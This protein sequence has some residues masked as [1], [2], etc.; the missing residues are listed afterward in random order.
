[1][2]CQHCDSNKNLLKNSTRPDGKIQ[3][4]CR[5]CNTERAKK[6]RKTKNGKL[7]MREAVYR[8]IEKHKNKQQARLQ[9][10]EAM[11]KGKILKKERCEK[12]FKN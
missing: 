4:M 3:W 7:K 6:Y 2:K 12:R 8:S 5:K 11:K 9:A 10:K 1:M